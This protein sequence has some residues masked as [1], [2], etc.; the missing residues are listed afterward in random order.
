M[1]IKKIAFIFLAFVSFS[2]SSD[3]DNNPVEN[4]EYLNELLGRYELKAAYLENPIDLNGDGIEG[5]DLFQEVEYCDMSKHLESYWAT[6]IDRNIQSL[7][8]DIPYS[9]HYNNYE[10]YTNCLRHKGVFRELNIDSQNESVTL[11]PNEY[12]EDFMLEFQAKLIDF[13]WENR[14]IYL[15]LEKEFYTPEGEWANVILYMEY[16]WVSDKT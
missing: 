4:Q 2:C 8:F 7:D 12:E 1:M 10:N 13:S 3:D 5:T 16:E 14:V 9:D 15:T 11:V 6:I